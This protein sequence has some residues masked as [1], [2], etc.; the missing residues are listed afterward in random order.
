MKLKDAINLYK[1][2]EQAVS[3]SYDW[4][5]KSAHN[6]GTVLIGNT[7]VPAYRKGRIWHIDDNMFDEAIRNHRQEIER[8][9]QVTA[10]Y[11]KGTIH[12][13][14]GDTIRTEWG[15]YAIHK[16]FRLV[17]SDYEQ[18]TKKSTGT[19]YCNKC[20]TVA[21]TEHEKEECDLCRDWNGC[22]TDCTLSKVRCPKCGNS[23]TL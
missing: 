23:F 7:R 3:N 10:D 12:G 15:G 4:Y 20:N 21:E 14:D 19:W 9:K 6:S 22:G 5:R 13:Q 8:L 11:A 18:L 17:W 1:K 2:E 16:G